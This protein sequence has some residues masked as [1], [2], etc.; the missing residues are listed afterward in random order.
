MSEHRITILGGGPGG[1]ALAQILRRHGVDCVVYEADVSA[2]ARHQGGMLNI[3]EHTGQKAIRLAGLYDEFQACVLTGADGVRLRGRDG[4]L[5]LDQIGDGSRP[6]IDRGRLRALFLEAL[7]PDVVRWNMRVLHVE[8]DASGFRVHFAD[9]STHQAQILVGADGTWSRARP[10]VSAAKPTYSGVKFVEYRYLHS[11]REYPEVLD[12]IGHGLFFA[13]EDERGFSGHREPEFELCVYAAAK[14][15]EAWGCPSVTR[16]QVID[17]FPGWNSAF[18]RA[19]QRSDGEP[20]VRPLYALPVGH[21]WERVPGVTLL[22]DAAHVMS[23]F[24]GEGVNL[25]LADAADLAEALLAYPADTEAA[26]AAYEAKMFSRAAESA[27][28]SAANLE[29]AFSAAGGQRFL[30]MFS[31]HLRGSRQPPGPP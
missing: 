30:E 12:L 27:A 4:R 2:A 23:P 19:L 25:A 13:L 6:E 8:H 31:G 16:Q 1:L 29:I 5:L 24:A 3:N 17:L 21:S 10:L 18:H 7:A 22:G 11:D 14:V 28:E 15:P 26:F 9:G 20:T